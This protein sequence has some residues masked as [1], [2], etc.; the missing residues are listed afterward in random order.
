LEQ[1]GYY[2]PSERHVGPSP[3]GS[4][5]SLPETE[6]DHTLRQGFT[7][8]SFQDGR[9]GLSQSQAGWRSVQDLTSS[10]V[11]LVP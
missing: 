7:G 10:Q 6:Y 3:A 1:L 4:F 8:F 5:I 9:S 11:S 2:Y